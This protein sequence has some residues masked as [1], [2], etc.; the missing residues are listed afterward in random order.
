ML[1]G[2]LALFLAGCSTESALPAT[3]IAPF[4]TDPKVGVSLASING[5]DVTVNLSSTLFK[6]IDPAKATSPH[7]YG[8]GHYH[9]FL[10]V[11]PTAPGEITPHAPGI[12]HTA[13]S[14]YTIHGVKDGHHHLS[15]VLGFTD[16][17]PYQDVAR[18]GNSVYGA[19]ASIDFATGS[20]QTQVTATQPSA[21]PSAAA[22]AAPSTAASAP[23]TAGGATT[24]IHVV[25]DAT[26]GGAY[27]P[28]TATVAVGATVEWVW[29]DDSASHTVT[30]EDGKFDSGLQA[31]G[32]K[33]SQPFK[34]A[35]TY[36]YKC[37]VHPQMLGTV[38]VQ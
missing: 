30:S 3:D 6:A 18:R 12:Y 26:N 16:H 7:V 25:A 38:K 32:Q 36:K 29:D 21:A 31:K 5:Q 35:G 1:L 33:F 17:T 14:T 34:A 13:E 37:S 10:D 27:N 4:K 24:T 19:I 8:E 9:V 15:V 23:A 22:S 20:G 11:P 2:A 28:G